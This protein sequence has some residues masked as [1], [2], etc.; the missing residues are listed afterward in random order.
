MNTRSHLHLAALL[1]LCVP[2]SAQDPAPKPAPPTLTQQQVDTIVKQLADVEKAI[3]QQRGANLG[4]IIQ[5][6]RAGT[7]SDAAALS[8]YEDCEKL[9]ADRRALTRDEKKTREE[10]VKKQAE[11][12]KESTAKEVKEDGDF[13]LAVRFQLRYLVLSLEAHE[14]KEIDKMLPE[15][16][17]Y[18]QDVVAASDKL[19][20]RAGAYLA[21]SLRGGGGGG[22]GR[23]GRG[24]GG[25]G[26]G[27]PFVPAFQI[28]DYL[29]GQRW[30][31]E[32]VDF[33]AMWEK[34]ILPVFREKKKSELGAQW[35]AR[36]AAE[37]G[38]KKG[39]ISDA[40][41]SLWQQN[42]VPDIKWAKLQDLFANG[43]KPVNAMADMLAMIRDNPGHPNSPKWLEEFKRMVAS[44]TPG[45]VPSTPGAAPQ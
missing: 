26:G 13:G 32:P 1:G 34:T 12:N 44:A 17:S 38:F 19:R 33:G 2:L 40:E 22:G 14:A 6:L 5:K 15:L 36:I 28:G 31:L 16:T 41:L 24:G 39:S 43:D 8:L 25:G 30:S 35:D 27:N 23:G 7:A 29:D 37:A 20:G 45:A 18:I 4:A 9:I 21:G 11:R 3:A 10:Q 42:E